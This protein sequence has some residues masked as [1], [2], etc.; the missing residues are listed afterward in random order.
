[1]TEK[2][3]EKRRQEDSS[4][5]AISSSLPPQFSAKQEAAF[6]DALRLMNDSGLPYAVSGAFALHEHTGIW[7]NTKDLDLFLPSEQLSPS[8]E[9]FK[10]AGFE[11][12]VPDPIWLG[13]AWR[14]GYFIDLIT[15][16][17]NAIIQVDQT[18]IDRATRGTVLGI[19]TPILSPEELV[20]SKIFVTRRERFDGAD[21]THLIYATRDSLDW[22]RVFQLVGDHWE[23]LLW[24]LMFFRYIYPRHANE[25]PRRVW[26]SL[27]EKLENALANPELDAPFRGS[28]ID[29]NMFAIDVKE[30]GLENEIEKYRGEHRRQHREHHAAVNRD[31]AAKKEP[32][33]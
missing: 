9:R 30:W 16:M 7:R 11:T 24:S 15:G 26:H 32:A 12:E 22:D 17:S 3:I 29:E 2:R 10:A 14:D 20:A 27:M 31:S 18:W 33:A 6:R 5:T 4:K 19:E 28:L 8:L 1:M 21:V 25:V 13:K 23:M